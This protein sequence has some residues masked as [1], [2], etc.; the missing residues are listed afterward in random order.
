MKKFIPIGLVIVVLCG[1]GLWA[2]APEFTGD[3]MKLADE[4]T[5]DIQHS[6]A[7]WKPVCATGMDYSMTDS[8]MVVATV[9]G[10]VILDPGE[11]LYIGFREIYT[12]DSVCVDTFEFC[13]PDN[14]EGAIKWPFAIQWVDSLLS[15]T[16][17]IDTVFVNAACKG[18]GQ[19]ESVILKNVYGSV[20]IIDRN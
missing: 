11:C 1:A 16:D 19:G 2:A 20:V 18:T 9:T 15:Q 17:D 4:V 8:C 3:V 6:A 13:A 10:Y 14:V 5:I 12:N 7:A